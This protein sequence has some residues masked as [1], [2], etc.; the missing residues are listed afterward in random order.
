M[1]VES[2]LPKDSFR[3]SSALS[4]T[5][6][7]ENPYNVERV[8]SGFDALCQEMIGHQAVRVHVERI[9]GGSMRKRLRSRW[10]S[11]VSEKIARRWNVHVVTK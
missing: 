9:V 5:F 2:F 7:F 6:N 10:E 3:L 8:A 4:V 11:F 1:V